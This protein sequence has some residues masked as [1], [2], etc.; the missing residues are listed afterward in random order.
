[1][2]ASYCA[3]SDLL[4]TPSI[5]E[6]PCGTTLTAFALASV[7]LTRYANPGTSAAG[8]R[9]TDSAPLVA[10]ARMVPSSVTIVPELENERTV[11]CERTTRWTARQSASSL[12]PT[13]ANGGI[14]TD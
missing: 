6:V 12:P 5:V 9:V 11:V 1:M 13:D 3:A 4:A 10:F 8:G 2:M 14:V 7:F